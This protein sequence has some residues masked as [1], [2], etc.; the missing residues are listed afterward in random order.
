METNLAKYHISLKTAILNLP[1]L[2]F[3]ILETG[4]VVVGLDKW[5]IWKSICST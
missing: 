4:T 5:N 2:A 3:L 1:D